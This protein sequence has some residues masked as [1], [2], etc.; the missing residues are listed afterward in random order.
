MKPKLGVLVSHPIQYLSPWFRYLAGRLD[1]EVFYAHRQDAHAQGQ[2][3]FGLDFEW[4]TPLT[5]GYP[6]RWL[7]NVASRPSVRSFSG[8]D[9]P[10]IYD[11]LR[12]RRFDGFL[13]FGWN[14]KSAMQAV[15]ACWRNKI[16]VLMRGDSQL[17][18]KRWWAKSAMKY[19]PYRWLLPRIDAHLYVGQRNRAYLKH[20]GVSDERLFF[21]PHFVDNG[22]FRQEA[23]KAEK[24]EKGSEARARLGIPNDAFVFL[25]V[26]K[27][28]PK[29]RPGDFVR[30]CLKLFD[31]ADGANAHAILA[32]DGPLRP[33]LQAV[34]GAHRI[35]FAGFLNQTQLPAVYQASNALVLPS[36][37][38]ETWGL[39]VN[40]AAACGVPAIISDAVGCGPDL[41]EEGRTG[42][43][44]PVG[45]VEALADRM[46]ELKRTS[47]AR[48][49]AIRHALAGK[50]ASYSIERATEGLETALAAV[51]RT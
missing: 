38:D 25:F 33:S 3:G 15:M 46:R 1:L 27:M 9:T 13:V 8:C 21:V 51:S 26:G 39:V 12:T 50:V 35:H 41:I 7:R 36:G 22:F 34:S 49:E 2:A 10:E 6:H 16:P 47:E 20:Y 40:E 31:T 45:E 23:Q 44:Y 4:D 5:D 48:P 17:M 18:M 30:A 11:L 24:E 14:R 19:F 42:Y 28:I 29:K 37:G 32:G 43:T